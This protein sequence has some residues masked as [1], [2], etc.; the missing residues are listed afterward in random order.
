MGRHAARAAFDAPAP[1]EAL[2]A[3]DRVPWSGSDTWSPD[4][5]VTD[6]RLFDAPLPP[7]QQAPVAPRRQAP[8]ARPTAPAEPRDT[9]Q[10]AAARPPA[11]AA[12]PAP[13][14]TGL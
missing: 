12:T 7:A 1:T 5:P 2:P 14:P 4:N 8:L 3:A 13:A 11:P 9:A 10:A 6:P